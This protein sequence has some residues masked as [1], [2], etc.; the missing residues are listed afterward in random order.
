M[1]LPDLLRYEKQAWGSGFLSPAGV[2]EA[3]VHWQ[4]VAAALVLPQAQ[5]ATW[6]AT[7]LKD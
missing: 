2:D 4:P 7:I 3:R 6:S 1:Q 5:A